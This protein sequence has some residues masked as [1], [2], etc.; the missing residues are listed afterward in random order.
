MFHFRWSPKKEQGWD[1]RWH[2]F[3]G[4]LIAK[5][6]YKE[7]LGLV[8][9]YWSYGNDSNSH[10]ITEKV[11][12]EEVKKGGRFEFYFNLNN[13]EPI[14]RNEVKYYADKDVVSIAQQSACDP[15]CIKHFKYK[16]TERSKEKMLSVI[17][18]QIAKK[19]HEIE[20]AAREIESLTERRTKIDAGDLTQYL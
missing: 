20:Y 7:K 12:D 4:T 8:D 19:K 2:C 10:W 6:D 17:N 11:I 18:E 13:V 9:T 14:D 15:S 16:G 3:Q 1:S 5:K